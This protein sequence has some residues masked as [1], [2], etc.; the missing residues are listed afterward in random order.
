[1]KKLL[2]LY[3]FSL[4]SIV[5]FSGVGYN[6]SDNYQKKEQENALKQ[7]R[8]DFD[9]ISGITW[10]EPKSYR[11]IKLYIGKKG[12]EVWLRLKMRYSGKDWIFFDKAYLSYDGNTFQVKFKESDKDSH[13]SSYAYVY[14]NIDIEVDESLL[15]YL[16]EMID[17]KVVKM[18]LSGDFSYTEELRKKDIKNIRNVLWAYDALN[19]HK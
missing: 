2:F 8:V 12:N 14:E 15:I 13:V 3:L 19:S 5:S 4:F 16:K 1:M 7:L 18:R 11:G 9:D 17:G 6:V 10:Y